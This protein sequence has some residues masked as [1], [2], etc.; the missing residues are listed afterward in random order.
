M[1]PAIGI[2]TNLRTIDPPSGERLAHTSLLSYPTMVRA[3]HL[4]GLVFTGGGDIDP[5]C[6]GCSMDETVYGIDTRRD[7]F[8]I[9]LAREAARRRIPTLSICRGMQVMNVALGGTLIVDI[10]SEE[11]DHL[12][13][14]NP[15]VNAYQTQHQVLLEAGSMVAKALGREVVDVNSIHHQAVR[16][17]AEGLRASGRAPDGIIE[18]LEPTDTTWPLLAVQWHPEDLGPEDEPSLSLFEALVRAAG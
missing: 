12:Q 5:S 3:D 2:T 1:R 17:L 14:W 9:A 10:E 11:G 6:Y 18:A 4:D 8:E 16:D 7:D 15:G 13:H